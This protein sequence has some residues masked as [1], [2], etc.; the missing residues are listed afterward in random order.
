[1]TVSMTKTLILKDLYF[2]R[3]FI[4]LAFL[5]GLVSLAMVYFGD[6]IGFYMGA[7]LLITVVV[8]LGMFLI[9][10]TVV[11]ERKFQTLPFIMSLPLTPLQYLRAKLWGN[12]FIYLMPW[13]LLVVATAGV[14]MFRPEIPNGLLPFAILVLVELL[15]AHCIILATAMI[16]E[17]QS[18]TIGLMVV[19]N[20]FFQLFLYVV[21]NHQGIKPFMEGPEPVWSPAF[22]SFFGILLA[23]GAAVLAV[24]F[25]VQSRKRDFL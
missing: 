14:V 20:L 18:W 12:L 3:V 24:A 19:C 22:F 13:T 5:L 7:I 10:E 15:A 1:M 9:F 11:N 21:S 2:S 25:W 6:K 17:S 23:T 16:S 8:G 4:L